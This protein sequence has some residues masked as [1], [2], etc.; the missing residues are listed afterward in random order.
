L[1]CYLLVHIPE[2][3]TR[4]DNKSESASGWGV[5]GYSIP[6]QEA[7]PRKDKGY[8]VPKSKLT[9]A[10]QI[11]RSVKDNP[12]PNQYQAAKPDN[13]QKE[14][15]APL[16]KIFPGKKHNFLDDIKKRKAVEPGPADYGAKI[17]DPKKEAKSLGA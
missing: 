3:D 7:L 1:N 10:S 8:S 16:G 5:E 6:V 4:S 12:G 13:W 17:I 2:V 11:T 15:K 9:Y 14:W